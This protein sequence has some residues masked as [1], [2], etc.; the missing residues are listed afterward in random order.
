MLIQWF[1]DGGISISKFMLWSWLPL[2][3]WSGLAWML[4]GGLVP[5]NTVVLRAGDQLRLVQSKRG[6]RVAN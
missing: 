4:G 5:G 2:L 6:T 1:R 3:I